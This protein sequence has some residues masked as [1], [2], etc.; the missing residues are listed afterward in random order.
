MIAERIETHLQNEEQCAVYL[1][2]GN[3]VLWVTQTSSLL[4][5]GLND[6]TPRSFG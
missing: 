4:D 2:E 5:V 3:Q 1:E 6:I